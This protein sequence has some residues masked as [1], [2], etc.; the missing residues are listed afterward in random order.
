MAKNNDDLA[1]KIVEVPTL[2]HVIIFLT[3]NFID[4]KVQVYFLIL[5]HILLFLIFIMIVIIYYF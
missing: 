3:P 4:K 1:L 5:C 2:P